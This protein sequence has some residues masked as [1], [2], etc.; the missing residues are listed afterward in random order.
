MAVALR[1]IC[2]IILALDV[3]T[4]RSLVARLLWEQDVAGSNPVVPTIIAGVVQCSTS[5][6]QA[7]DAGSIPVARSK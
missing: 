2:P 6:F 7:D 3:G 5:A 1:S 4:W